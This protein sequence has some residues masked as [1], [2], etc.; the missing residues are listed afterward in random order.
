[1]VD[2]DD[3][4]DRHHRNKPEDNDASLIGR[5]IIVIFLIGI[6]AGTGYLYI[7]QHES[8]RPK[9]PIRRAYGNI[10]NTSTEFN[11]NDFH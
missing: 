3:I 1:M 4:K 2:N 10:Q 9:V 11:M 5:A 7:K 8:K 6:M